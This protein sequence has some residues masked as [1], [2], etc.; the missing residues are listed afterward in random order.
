[1]VH[2]DSQEGQ[3]DDITNQ[4]LAQLKQEMCDEVQYHILN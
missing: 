2:E 1:M 3:H 4:M